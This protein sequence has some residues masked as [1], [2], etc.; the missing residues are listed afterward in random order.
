MN[1][2]YCHGVMGPEEDWKNR[3]YNK[4]KNWK[5]WLQF[6]IEKDKNIIMQIPK[7]P[8]AHAL[9]MKYDEWEKVMD[10]QD[11]NP[12]TVLIGHS[13]GGGF[14]LKYLAKHPNLKIRQI[15]LVA[16]WI[17]VI[18]FQPFGFYK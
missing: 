14:I 11:I 5:D 7:F 8:N 17:D 15:I 9:L 6:Q 1:I 18:D 16:P 3:Q 13:A 10:F 2:I 4:I 12:D